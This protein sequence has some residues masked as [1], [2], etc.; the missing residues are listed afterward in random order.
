[1]KRA[2][3][4]SISTRRSVLDFSEWGMC[5]IRYWD[6]DPWDHWDREDSHHESTCDDPWCD[7][8]DTNWRWWLRNKMEKVDALARQLRA[9][10]HPQKARRQEALSRLLGAKKRFVE[11]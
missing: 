4:P 5:D 1:M 11:G 2:A 10:F 9:K 6:D 7:L 8:C 3:E